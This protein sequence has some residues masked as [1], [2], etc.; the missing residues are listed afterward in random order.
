MEPNGDPGH[1][2]M[3]SGYVISFFDLRLKGQVF[4]CHLP[5]NRFCADEQWRSR[6]AT[7]AAG[8]FASS[9]R[10]EL[11]EALLDADGAAVEGSLAPRINAVPMGGLR[12]V[13]PDAAQRTFGCAS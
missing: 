11:R 13:A 6:C 8:T 4:E 3:A 12:S 7:E 9:A 10:R 1:I 2:S 5:I